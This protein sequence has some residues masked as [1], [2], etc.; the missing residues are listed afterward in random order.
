[1]LFNTN[2]KGATRMV[3]S[4]L[5]FHTVQ[6][7]ESLYTNIVIPFQLFL[8]IY[9]YNALVYSANTQAGE[10]ILIIVAFLLNLWRH[11][12]GK[13]GN[14]SKS[15][16][17]IVGYLVL[18]IIIVIGFLYVGL[19]QPYIYWLEFIMALIAI[20]FVALEFL[21]AVFTIIAFK[22]S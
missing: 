15:I 8:F 6:Y 3:M 9:K 2:E 7:Y 19:W 13:S 4:S 17:K 12:L 20:I 14:R 16:P 22:V 5:Y 21:L 11:S 18:S 1:M 10:V